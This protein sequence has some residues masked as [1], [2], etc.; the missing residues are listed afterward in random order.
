MRY[1]SF[2]LVVLNSFIFFL[3]GCK[4][5]ASYNISL[6]KVERNTKASEIYGKM[7]IDKFQKDGNTSFS[8]EDGL[9]KSTWIVGYDQIYFEI[10][11]KINH[12]IKIIWDD[13]VYVDENG[14]SHRVMH[15]GI[16]YSDRE[17]SM[18][19]SV[20]VRKEK[21]NRYNNSNRSY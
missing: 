3:T 11:N 1:I 5:Y 16:K 7:K 4:P 13:A 18:V 15:S 10:N 19:P 20:I 21:I 12:S 2:K 9:I 14:E 6:S 17:K 8:F